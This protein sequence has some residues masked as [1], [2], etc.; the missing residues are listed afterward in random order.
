MVDLTRCDAKGD[1]YLYMSR[2]KIFF[3]RTCH[4]RLPPNLIYPLNMEVSNV[5]V[6]AFTQAR[7]I[8]GETVPMTSLLS[9]LG[10]PLKV[11]LL[12]RSILIDEE[13]PITA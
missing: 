3:T 2:R 4:S 13:L 8:D 12:K 5:R 11:S 9:L 1:I 7:S 6:S 10:G